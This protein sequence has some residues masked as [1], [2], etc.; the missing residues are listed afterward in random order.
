MRSTNARKGAIVQPAVRP[1]GDRQGNV[2]ACDPAPPAPH[3][4][5]ILKKR[6]RN[7]GK[8][9]KEMTIGSLDRGRTWKKSVKRDLERDFLLQTRS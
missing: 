3:S 5:G 8:P 7:K 2:V 1:L 4:Y 6:K 9:V